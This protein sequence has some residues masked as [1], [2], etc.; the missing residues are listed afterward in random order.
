MVDRPILDVHRRV[1]AAVAEP[2]GEVGKVGE[3]Q[4][5]W[6]DR[7][8]VLGEP[9]LP[10]SPDTGVEAVRLGYVRAPDHGRASPLLPLQRGQNTSSPASTRC[11]S[12]SMAARVV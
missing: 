5:S 2:L 9:C 11:N 4:R 3:P 12:A 8:R 6:A 10:R 1:A 7:A